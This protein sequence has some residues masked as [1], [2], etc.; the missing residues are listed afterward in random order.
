MKESAQT[1][2]VLC[3]QNSHKA[4]RMVGNRVC[5]QQTSARLSPKP[6]LFPN[7][8]GSGRSL[9]SGRCAALSAMR[10]VTHCLSHN[11]QQY[12]SKTRPSCRVWHA[13]LDSWTLSCLQALSPTQRRCLLWHLQRHGDEHVQHLRSYS[14]VAFVTVKDASALP[15]HH[16]F[17]P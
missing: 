9:S 8:I 16:E 1:R 5:L 14:W 15:Y 4:H 2:R 17:A 12:C 7:A 10:Q 3:R 11:W 13:T 6:Q